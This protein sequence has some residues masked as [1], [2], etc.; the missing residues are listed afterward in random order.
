MSSAPLASYQEQLRLAAEFVM[1][2]NDV[3]VVSH[4]QPDGDAAGSTF[5]VGHMLNSL[6]KTFTLVNE[7]TMPEKYRFM[8]GGLSIH[9]YE[10]VQQLGQRFQAVIAV[11]CADFGR[12]GLVSE[13]IAS[14]TPFLN[15]DHHATNDSFGTVNLI[16]A[17]AAAT[18]EILYDLA[19]E[20]NARWTPELATCL[21]SGLLTDTG[22][23]RYSNTS[24][25]VMETAGRLL[26]LGAKGPELAERLLERVTLA[27]IQLL[28]RALST[29]ALAADNRVAWMTVTLKDVEECG[30]NP[31]DLDGLVNY[32]RNIEGVEVGLLFKQSP[33]G[34]V[35]VGFRSSGTVDVAE[36]A[37]SLG[38]GGHRRAA[39]A[40]VQL[41]MDE[42]VQLVVGRVVANL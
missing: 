29:L 14:G 7:G 17:D 12:L 1:G 6:G 27:Q 32:P 16:Q 40:S 15:I 13:L 42:A 21:Y 5:A 34:G 19:I 4:V 22:G 9:T 37:Q 30:A 18:A 25:K 28:R 20:M 36:I 33:K 2:H 35:K 10:S 41:E 31:E 39:G 3:L 11:D 23:F 24:T 38:G 8:S 26:Q